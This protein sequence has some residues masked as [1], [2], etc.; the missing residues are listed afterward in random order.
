MQFFGPLL[1]DLFILEAKLIGLPAIT[2]FQD[3][4]FPPLDLGDGSHSN[5]EERVVVLVLPA[6]E[7]VVHQGNE[8]LLP[9]FLLEEDL[10][11]L[12][13]LVDDLI[14]FVNEEILVQVAQRTVN[15]ALEIDD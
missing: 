10:A 9:S 12:G 6:I 1:K 8:A 2:N 13:A 7:L 4:Y 14:L 15:E 3:I 5:D 11:A